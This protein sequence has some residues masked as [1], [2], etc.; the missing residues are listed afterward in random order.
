MIFTL[1]CSSLYISRTRYLKVTLRQA[2]EIRVTKCTIRDSLLIVTDD[3]NFALDRTSHCLENAPLLTTN[4]HSKSDIENIIVVIIIGYISF[5][6]MMLLYTI[7]KYVTVLLLDLTSLCMFIVYNLVYL[8]Y[9]KMIL[10]EFVNF[11]YFQ[12]YFPTYFQLKY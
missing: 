9:L 1:F 7:K 6:N 12:L 10:S 11:K 8:N 4:A 2:Q 5:Y 3:Q